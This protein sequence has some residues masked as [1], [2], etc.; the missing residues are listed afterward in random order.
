MVSAVPKI[1]PKPKWFK[2]DEH[3]KVGDVILFTK[4]DSSLTSGA[5]RLGMVD[6]I[7]RS[8]D[9]RIRSVTVRYRK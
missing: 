5:Y 2:T 9:G 8:A 7:N 4:D 3:L 1:M 6:S